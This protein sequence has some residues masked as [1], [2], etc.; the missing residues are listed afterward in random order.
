MQRGGGT[1]QTLLSQLRYLDNLVVDPSQD[2]R[3]AA[4][5]SEE[6]G[7]ADIRRLVATSQTEWSWAYMP[8]VRLWVSLG[9]E[10]HPQRSEGKDGFVTSL[11]LDENALDALLN[12][13]D[14]IMLYHFHPR[15]GPLKEAYNQKALEE[16]ESPDFIERVMAKSAVLSAM[17]SPTDFLSM[18][19][20]SRIFYRRRSAKSL[21]AKVCSPLGVTEF[22]LT[23]KGKRLYKSDY[24]IPLIR[25]QINF[26]KIVNDS[27]PEIAALSRWHLNPSEGIKWFTTRTSNDLITVRFTPYEIEAVKNVNGLSRSETHRVLASPA[28]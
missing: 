12:S 2:H 25:E 17:P 18:I 11:E 19:L 26:Y 22:F 6:E 8:K 28:H 5:R 3:T 23:E 9:K 21:V 24:A 14:E 7:V 27:A 13:Y 1:S 4:V 16:G 10:A 15:T 20:N